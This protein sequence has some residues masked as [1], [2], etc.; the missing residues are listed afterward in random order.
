VLHLE[1]HRPTGTNHGILIML[2][3]FG[4]HCG[5]YRSVAAGFARAG[6]DVTAFDCRGH[7]RSTGRRGYVR[8]FHDFQED[9]H[10][11]IETARAAN[12][13][14]APLALLGH[15]HGATIAL[16]YALANR[17][18]VAALVL[19]SP[20]FALKLKIPIWKTLLGRVAGLAWPTLAVSSG[21]RSA[22]TT[23][24]PLVRERLTND[25][26]AHHVATPRWYNEVRATQAH[27]LRSAS[28]LRVPTFM[29]LAGDDR[30]VLSEAAQTFARNAGSIVETKVYDQ[31]FHEL[32]LEPDWERIADECASWLV[33]RLMAPYT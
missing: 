18:P 8:R 14:G 28:T 7:G 25:P 32:F 13:R 19:A 22:D 2:H 4:V 5:I 1:R 23:R 6:L 24:D 10:L 9:L 31:A 30:L 15:S 21:V 11:V 27:I 12:D 3:G 26:I 29:A 16:D 20:Y 33:A 17:S